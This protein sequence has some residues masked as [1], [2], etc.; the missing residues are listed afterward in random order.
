MRPEDSDRP[1]ARH[2]RDLDD[3]SPAFQTLFA[4]AQAM[5]P[6]S[7]LAFARKIRRVELRKREDELRGS[8][9]RGELEFWEED[10][11]ALADAEA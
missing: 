8:N 2:V 4:Q 11:P 7:P 3:R 10:F 1:M 6:P 5:H 9:Q